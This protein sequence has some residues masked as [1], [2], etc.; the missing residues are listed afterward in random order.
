[1]ELADGALRQVLLGC[2][3]IMTGREIRDDLLANP[4]AFQ[5]PRLGVGETPFKIRHQT[6]ISTLLAK[7]VRILEVE[8]F[9]GAAFKQLI[10]NI[11]QAV[12]DRVCLHLPRIGA[13]FP[14]A[15]IGWP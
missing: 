13:P 15:S 14:L 9:V 7:V 2:R 10:H 12:T 1:M 6:I 4:T 5:D 8:S 11:L 3:Q